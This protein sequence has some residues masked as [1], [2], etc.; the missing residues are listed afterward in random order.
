MRP[1][2][3]FAILY[4]AIVVT[5][6]SHQAGAQQGG[7]LLSATPAGDSIGALTP[8]T[9]VPA[10][11]PA[12]AASLSPRNPVYAI[13][14]TTD[15]QRKQTDDDV[16]PT[17]NPIFLSLSTELQGQIID[18]SQSFYGDCQAR[19]S[20]AVMHNCSCLSI[21]YMNQ[22]IKHP[23]RSRAKIG[24]DIMLDC[25]DVPA[26]AGYSYN[27]CVNL[28][29]SSYANMIKP[30]CECYASNFAR[31][32]ADHPDT[33]SQYEIDLGVKTIMACRRKLTSMTPDI[34]A[35]VSV[36]PPAPASP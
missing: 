30:L 18:E 22:R 29:S 7:G 17:R 5:L 2:A 11:S 26:V 8:L 24:D 28:Y 4:L 13:P 6:A 3:R 35:G 34:A 14:G 23:D 19:T 33:T 36:M 25:V 15:R 16:D 10:V 21:H 31:S 9:S 12:P 27:K 20:Y 32:Y 1:F